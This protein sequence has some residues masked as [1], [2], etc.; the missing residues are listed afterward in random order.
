MKD[1]HI[2]KDTDIGLYTIVIDGEETYE[3]L[4]KDE[5]VEIISDYMENEE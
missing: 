2:Y 3:C 5:V 4:A 1:I